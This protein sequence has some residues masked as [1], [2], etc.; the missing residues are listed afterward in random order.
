MDTLVGAGHSI[1]KSDQFAYNGIELSPLGQAIIHGEDAE[2]WPG[3]GTARGPTMD[4]MFEVY[5][6]RYEDTGP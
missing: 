5:S 4:Q 2:R 1:Y 3:E 6:T